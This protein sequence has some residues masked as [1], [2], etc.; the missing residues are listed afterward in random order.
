LA[1]PERGEHLAVGQ[2]PALDHLAGDGGVGQVE[3][4]VLDVLAERAGLPQE[5]GHQAR[6]DDRPG[7]ERRAVDRVVVVDGQHRTDAIPGGTERG[8]RAT[9]AYPRGGC[10]TTATCSS[11]SSTPG[12]RSR[13]SPGPKPRSSSATWCGS[14]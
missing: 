12:R 3:P 6:R 8:C 2:R 14:A 4:D 9:W 10:L 11:G 1:D 5:V 13:R 7:D